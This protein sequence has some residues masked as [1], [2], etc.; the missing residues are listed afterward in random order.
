[1]K[2]EGLSEQSLKQLM[3]QWLDLSIEKQIPISYL[4]LI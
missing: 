3:S 1:M 4:L 2:W